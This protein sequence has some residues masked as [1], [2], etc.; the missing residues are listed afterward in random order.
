MLP[1]EVLIGKLT[2]FFF[3]YACC[4]NP[5]IFSTNKERNSIVQFSFSDDDRETFKYFKEKKSK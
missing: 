3:S 4:P 1:S 5:F 2:F